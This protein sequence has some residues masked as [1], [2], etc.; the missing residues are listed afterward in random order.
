MA[1]KFRSPDI[2]DRPMLDDATSN[3]CH[4]T[5]TLLQEKMEHMVDEFNAELDSL[6]HNLT[7]K[8]KLAQSVSRSL[9]WVCIARIIVKLILTILFCRRRIG[10]ETLAK[11]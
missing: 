7:K 10:L 9:Y 2:K 6:E 4:S 8:T 11:S 1:G 5:I 3:H